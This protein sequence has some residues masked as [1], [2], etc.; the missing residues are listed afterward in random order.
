MAEKRDYYEVLGVSKSA[1]EDEIKKA[2]RQKAKQYHPDLNQGDDEAEVKFKEANEAYEVLSDADKKARY[3]QFGHRGVDPNFGAGGPGGP[4]GGF[5]GG[6]EFDL[7]DLFGDIFG[8]FGGFGSSRQ[9]NPNAP[10]RGEDLQAR[11][12]VSFEEAAKGCKRVIEVNKV[13]VCPDCSGSGAQKGTEPKICPECKG[14]GQVSV[15]QRTPFGVVSSAKAC[16]KCG[17]R[18]KIVE[19]PCTKCHGRGRVSKKKKLE[20]SIPPGIDDGQVMRVGGEGNFGINGGPPGDLHVA[21]FVRPHPFFERDGYNVWCDF[22]ITYPQAVFGGNLRVPTLD[23]KV[24]FKIPAGTQAGEVFVLKGKGI[25]VLN[26]RGRGDQLVRVI[27]DVP[28]NLNHEQKDL[29]KKY[30][31]SFGK[32]SKEEDDGKKNGV[33]GKGKR[34]K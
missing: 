11:V 19:N 7:G 16:P 28:K 29:L 27:V 14:Q 26:G 20:V 5:G 6:F 1:T 18:G 10:R 12:T 21:V 17:G 22:T 33:F 9:A 4:G 23:G 30:Q 24:D 8:G 25:K 31:D 15:Q 3:D 32:K 2:Y 34:R 13:E